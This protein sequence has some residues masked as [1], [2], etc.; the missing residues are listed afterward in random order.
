[1]TPSQRSSTRRKRKAG[2]RADGPP[3][4]GRLLDD[5]E[6]RFEERDVEFPDA[7]ALWLLAGVLDRLDDP[8]ALLAERRKRVAAEAADRFRALVERRERHEPYQ[9]IV[10]VVDFRGALMEIDAGL[11]VPREQTER[12]CDE[13]EAWAKELPVPPGGWRIAELGTGVGAMAVSLAKGPLAPSTVLAVDISDKALAVARR[14]V[15][16]HGVED[17]VRPVMGDWL[18]MIRPAPCLDVICAVPPYLNPGDE[19]W[20]SEESLRWE[21]MESFF[22]EPSGDTVLRMI[23]DESAA[24]LRPGGLVA[25][26]ADSDQ[27]PGLVDY[28]NDDPEHP[29][30][31]E[32]ILQDE[33]GDED[34]V[35]AVKPASE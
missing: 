32:W 20:L 9:Y 2:A 23:L 4:V 19:I 3:T 22:G 26:Q 29:L 24:R 11:F 8:D 28:V 5:A 27:I 12:M 1:M 10:G 7:S 33:E 6:R 13:I 18:T 14:N 34:A 21:P 17:V 31:I 30:T 25:L 16:R 15:R 35:L